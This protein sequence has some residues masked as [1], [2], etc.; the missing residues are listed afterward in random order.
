MTLTLVEPAIEFP[1]TLADVKLLAGVLNNT[2]DNL[3][4]SFIPAA[5]QMVEEHVGLS[6]STQTWSVALPCFEEA[7][8]LPRGPV[9]G[10]TSIKYYEAAGELLTVDPSVWSL[11][12][13][14][15]PPR[16]IRT[17]TKVWPIPGCHPEPIRVVY[18][19]G[20]TAAD[21]VP[22]LL[23]SA[24]TSLVAHWFETRVIGDLPDGI[25]RALS[26]F[27]RICI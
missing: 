21:E 25:R 24:I 12:L 15:R 17:P 4:D 22:A 13:V 3:L 11:D 16:V 5:C 19:A 27:R 18:V 7:L 10:V 8:D 2:F 9:Q 26:P 6:L 20:Y 1:V 23:R 14:N